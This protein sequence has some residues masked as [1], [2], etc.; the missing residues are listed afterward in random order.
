MTFHL[1]ERT[2]EKLFKSQTYSKFL[3][4]EKMENL[5]LV[6]GALYMQKHQR[7]EFWD[8]KV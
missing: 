6:G 8:A 4:G 3:D 2:L 5:I 1:G 7:Y